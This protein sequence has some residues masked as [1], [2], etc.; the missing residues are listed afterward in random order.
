MATSEPQRKKSPRAPSMALDEALERTMK[1]YDKERL[2]AAPTDVIA[3]HMGYKGA[4]NGAALSAL[5]SI[6]YYGLVDRAGDGLLAVTKDVESYRHAPS[7]EI[8]R[9]FLRRFMTSPPIFA[10]L[11]DKYS[12][13]LPSDGNLKYELINRGF[14]PAAAASLVT[15]L[16]QSVEF[17]GVQA[18]E[19]NSAEMSTD[20]PI[21]SQ[22]EARPLVNMRSAGA[23]S[24]TDS[25]AEVNSSDDEDHD[26][27]PVRLPGG[28]RAWLLIPNVFFESD[29]TRIKA[30]IDLLLTEEDNAAS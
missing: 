9:S 23:T 1:V 3:Q 17:V 30:Q 21:A 6:R 27:I 5:A 18:E 26:R 22:D 28:R 29:K 19:S 14:T 24:Q 2:H 16:R 4:N 10:E 12:T 8:R 7:E 11:L 15:V 25:R 20:L 13:G